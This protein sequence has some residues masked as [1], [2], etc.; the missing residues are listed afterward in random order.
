ML[1]R[2]QRNIKLIKIFCNLHPR[3]S[4]GVRLK[5]VISEFQS[6][7]VSLSFLIPL[8]YLFIHNSALSSIA[9][10]GSRIKCTTY[11]QLE[12]RPERQ[13]HLSDDAKAILRV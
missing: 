6:S 13:K 8:I 9:Q 10:L 2:D 4:H 12:D 3:L 11:E 7:Y 1:D 5:D